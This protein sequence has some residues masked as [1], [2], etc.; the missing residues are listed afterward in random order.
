MISEK[1]ILE[2]EVDE[3]NYSFNFKVDMSIDCYAYDS[4]FDNYN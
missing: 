4:V 2:I 3:N 1:I